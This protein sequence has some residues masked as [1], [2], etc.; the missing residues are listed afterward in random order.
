[1]RDALGITAGTPFAVQLAVWS[2]HNSPGAF[3][4]RGRTSAVEG[5]DTDDFPRLYSKDGDE[6]SVQMYKGDSV[7]VMLVHDIYEY[8]AQIVNHNS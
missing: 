8:Y 4:L 7:Q 3:T 1:M 5:A 2:K 6:T